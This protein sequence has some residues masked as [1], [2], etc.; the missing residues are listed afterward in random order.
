MDQNL[1]AAIEWLQL[2]GSTPLEIIATVSAILGVILIARQN[3]LGW[4]LGILWATV[5]A[6]LAITEWQLVS[7]GD[8]KSVV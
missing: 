3:I 4:P 5:S 6:W 7:D 2:F 1:F 8:R